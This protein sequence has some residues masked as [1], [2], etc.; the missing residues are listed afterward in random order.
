MRLTRGTRYARNCNPNDSKSPTTRNQTVGDYA[1]DLQDGDGSVGDLFQKMI[2]PITSAVPYMGCEGNHEGGQSFTHYS[3]RFA[4]F[5]RD[6][7]SPPA[8]AVSGLAPS[9]T[10]AHWYSY[11]VGLVHYV[12]VSTEAFFFYNGAAAQLAWLE[13]DLAAVDRAATPWLIVAGHR[14]IYCSCDG[15]CDGAATT[16]RNALE[17][18]F[19]AHGVDL[20]INGHEHDYERNYAVR[21]F[22]KAVA[23]SGAP[24]GN[25]SAPEVLTA[26][27]APVYIVEGCAGDKENHEP[28]TRA[29]PAYSAYRSNT[30]GYSRMTV[31]N[32]SH[33]L[34]EQIQTDDEPAYAKTTGTVIDAMLLV[35]PRHGPFA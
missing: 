31:Y 11:N 29:Q 4:V 15:D 27:T 30:Y 7:S 20:W 8:P 2:E 10:N 13:A 14:S 23:T 25:A 5:A 22:T 6:G 34:W 19:L 3:N 16:V 17:A 35:Q 18:I 28:F 21:D 26:P 32:A 33:L 24:G 1:Y 12:M 9:P